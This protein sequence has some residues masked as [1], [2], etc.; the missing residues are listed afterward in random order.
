MSLLLSLGPRVVLLAAPVGCSAFF[1]SSESAIFSLP[2]DGGEPGGDA[3]AA[4]PTSR[5]RTSTTDRPAGRGPPDVDCHAIG[6]PS[7]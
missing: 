7:G 6:H 2:A 3:S 4:T 1:S 5:N